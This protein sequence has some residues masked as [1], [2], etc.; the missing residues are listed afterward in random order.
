MANVLNFMPELEP[1]E[2]AFVQ[3]VMQNMNDAQAQQFTN[4][5]RSRRKDPMLILITAA[6]GFFGAAGI[7]RFITGDIGMGVVYLLTAGFCFIGTIVDVINYK[8][9]TFKYNTKEAQRAAALVMG[10]YGGAPSFY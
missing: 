1:D 10:Q 8:R 3:T 2:M 9:L 5:Y 7:H 6:I 4:I